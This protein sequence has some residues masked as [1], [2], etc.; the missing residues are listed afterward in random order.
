MLRFDAIKLISDLLI[1][2]LV[3]EVNWLE[4]NCIFIVPVSAYEI[5]AHTHHTHTEQ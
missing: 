3:Y 2:I 1:I 5:P 4:S